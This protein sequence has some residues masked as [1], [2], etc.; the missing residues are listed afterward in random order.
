[1]LPLAALSHGGSSRRL[2]N[3]KPYGVATKSAPRLRA[4]APLCA[5]SWSRSSCCSGQS[6][7]TATHPVHAS[8][9]TRAQ[10]PLQRWGQHACAGAAARRFTTH[11]Y[12]SISTALVFVL[13]ALT[14]WLDGFLARK[15]RLAHVGDGLWVMRVAGAVARR[16]S[17]SLPCHGRWISTGATEGEQQGQKG[18]GALN[19]VN[20]HLPCP[21]VLP[22]CSCA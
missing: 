14:D 11:Q 7:A 12:A 15:V 19:A 8:I 10:S 20:G 5:S 21:L 16:L 17:A 3:S 9:C 2:Q 18:S 22:P 4:Q 6:C 1:M 13:A